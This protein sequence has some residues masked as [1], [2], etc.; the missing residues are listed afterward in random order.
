VSNN[1]KIVVDKKGIG[2]QDAHE[3]VR[4]VAQE[5]FEKKQHLK[6]LVIKKGLLS[7]DEALRLFDY[8]TYIG[9]A[10]EIVKRSVK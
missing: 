3:Q 2:R 5:A 1:D 8:S 4:L 10:E 9:K 7:K 6:D